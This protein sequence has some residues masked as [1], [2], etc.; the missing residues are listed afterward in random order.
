M[1][2]YE[3]ERQRKAAERERAPKECPHCGAAINQRLSEW[4]RVRYHCGADKCRKATS[5]A[6]I[7][8]RKRIEREEIS[9]Q[10]DDY[11]AQLPADQRAAILQAKGLL[12]QADYDQGHNLMLAVIEVL[13]AQRCK[14]DRIK[15]LEENA[16]IWKRRAL[17]SEEQLNARIKELEEEIQ[18]FNALEATIHG[19]AAY[20]LQQQPDPPAQTTPAPEA[21]QPDPD[22]ARTLAVLAQAGIKPYGSKQEDEDGTEGYEGEEYDEEEDPEE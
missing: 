9:K 19:I 13:K 2:Y 1:S 11:A 10:I 4:D 15:Q 18:L 8:E 20:Q 17:A 6:N 14:H 5:R 3:Q 21:A 22:R 16:A 12:M 7:A